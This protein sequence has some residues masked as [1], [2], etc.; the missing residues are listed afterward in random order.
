MNLFR[1]TFTVITPTPIPSDIPRQDVV[2]LLHNHIAMMDMN[3]LVI[4]HTPFPLPH[5]TPPWDSAFLVVDTL[6]CCCCKPKI[7]Y[8]VLFRNTPEGLETETKPSFLGITTKSVWAFEQQRTGDGANSG[9]VLF[10]TVKVTCPC[11]VRP[12]VVDET[13]S[14][15]QELSQKFLDRLTE[16]QSQ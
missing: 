7:T 9:L 11:F 3:P 13:T 15:R 14:S 6:P 10:E 4:S 8:T 12:F 16:S 1:T 5:A 2:N